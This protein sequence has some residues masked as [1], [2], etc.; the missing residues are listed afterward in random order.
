[1][2]NRRFLLLCLLSG[3]LV[4][5]GCGER[6]ATMIPTDSEM[7][8]DETGNARPGDQEGDVLANKKAGEE[9]KGQ[10]DLVPGDV[11]SPGSPLDLYG[12][13]AP[14]ASRQIEAVDPATLATRAIGPAIC[15]RLRDLVAPRSFV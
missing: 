4:H 9:G 11:V 14:K 5:A 12:G 13:R 15:S 10:S 6:E 1:M 8:G 3:A 2:M 7:V